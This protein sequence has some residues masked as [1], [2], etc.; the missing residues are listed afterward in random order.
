MFGMLHTTPSKKV[1]PRW[2]CRSFYYVFWSMQ[3]NYTFFAGKV[4]Y[5]GAYI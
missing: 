5:T 2:K 3:H 4:F 1:E